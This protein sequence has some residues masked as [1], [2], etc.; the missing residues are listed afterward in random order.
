MYN[1]DGQKI[2]SREFDELKEVRVAEDKV[3]V[4]HGSKVTIIE[5]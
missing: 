2:Y 1:W 5:P 4:L 3:V